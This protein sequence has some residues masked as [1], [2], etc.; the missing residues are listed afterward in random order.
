MT[1]RMLAL[2]LAMLCMGSLSCA[3]AEGVTLRTASSFAGTEYGAQAYVEILAEWEVATGNYADDQS[4][5][6]D[7]TW[8]A[9]VLNDF[10]VGNEP[11]VLFFFANTSD[12][13]PILDKVVPIDEIN[14]AYP[15]LHL[16]EAEALRE[17]NGHVYAVMVRPFWEALFV[18]TDMFEAAGLELPTDAEKFETAIA[19]FNELGITPISISLSD[20]PHYIAEMSI[21]ATGPVA[22]HQV[23]P[24]T[25]EEIPQSWYDGMD[26]IRHLSLIGAFAKNASYTTND[27]SAS[28]FIDKKAAMMLDGSWRANS[29][30]EQNWETTLVMPFPT[31]SEDADPTA[32]VG[33]VSMG[34]Y[35]TRKAWE[36]PQKRDAAVE[37]LAWMT[38]EESAERLGFAFGGKLK[39]S[40]QV[41]Y[42]TAVANG[43]IS[44]PFQDQM[45]PDARMYWMDEIPGIADGSADP[46]QVLSGTIERGAF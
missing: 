33:G 45:D 13:R 46:V 10:A 37:L 32:I 25:V 40:S 22:D 9:R 38:S 28:V 23:R 8:K 36:D 3:S 6:S 44:A 24:K 11:D 39:A 29:I 1:K 26:L 19:T 15:D 2:L 27:L 42:D 14:A 34:F 35:I 18:N 5:S 43:T 7:E 17:E 31:Y 20:V 41:M 21:L 16:P 30:P 12:S 4:Y